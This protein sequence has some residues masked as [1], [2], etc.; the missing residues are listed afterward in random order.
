ALPILPRRTRVIAQRH[1]CV[2]RFALETTAQGGT[3][4]ESA[5]PRYGKSS[6]E[7]FDLPIHLVGQLLVAQRAPLRRAL[8][9][10]NSID[11]QLPVVDGRAE[12]GNR[13]RLHH[14]TPFLFRRRPAALIVA[15]PAPRRSPASIAR[16]PRRRGRARARAADRVPYRSTRVAPPNHAAEPSPASSRSARVGRRPRAQPIPAAAA[17]TARGYRRVPAPGYRTEPVRP[18]R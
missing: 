8:G 1:Y 15:A 7:G 13:I 16:Y 11:P 9:D 17:R 3:G 14:R 4:L 12:R 6:A 10:Q 18:G 2:T 5:E